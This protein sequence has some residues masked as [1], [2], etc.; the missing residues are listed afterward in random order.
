MPRFLTPS[1]IGLLALVVL[2]ADSVLPTKSTVPFLTF[3]VKYILPPDTSSTSDG[4]SALSSASSAS[5]P[6]SS[7]ILL[8]DFQEALIIHQSI[9]P[10][11]NMWDLFLKKLWEINSLDALFLFFEGLPAMIAKTRQEKEQDI[12]QGL[13]P[14]DTNKMLLSRASPMGNFVRRS[15]LE[16]TRLQF[17]DSK[18]LW[19]SLVSFRNETLSE[20]KRR[21]STAGETSFDVNLKD[22][23]LKWEDQLTT[24]VYEKLKLAD[25][26]KSKVEGPTGLVSTDDVERLLEFQVE[27]M[28]KMGNR[29]PGEIKKQLRTMLDSGVTVPSL[30]QY[31]KF[32]DAWRAGD[33]PTSFES[34]HRYFDYTMH[35]R[36]RTFYQYAL[37]NLAILQADFGCYSE[38]LAA[39]RETIA[40]ARENKD[41][42]CLNFSLSWLYHFGKVH[43]GEVNQDTKGGMMGVER[44]GLAFLKAKAKENGMWSLMATSLL[45]EARMI[46]ANHKGE[47]L[48]KAFENI[49]QSSHLS[50]VKGVTNVIG[51]QV[52]LKSSLWSRLGQLAIAPHLGNTETNLVFIPQESALSRLMNAKLSSLACV[53]QL[54]MTLKGRYDDAMAKLDEIEVED[55]KNLRIYQYWTTFSGLLKLKR[56]LHRGNFDAA[57]EFLSQL[58]TAP[59]VD[60]DVSFELTLLRYDLLIRR[61]DYSGALALLEKTFKELEE[62]PADIHQRIRLMTLKA[63]LFDKC[64][65]TQ[66]GW[67]IAVRAMSIAKRAKNLSALYAAVGAVSKCLVEFKE[68]DAAWKLMDS[69]MPQIHEC[70]DAYLI[71]QSYSCFIDATM[72]LAGEAGHGS[73]KRTEY[74]TK[75]QDLLDKAFAEFSHAEDIS[76]MLEVL[77]KKSTAYKMSGDLVLC[78]EYALK[79]VALDERWDREGEVESQWG[80][81]AMVNS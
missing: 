6:V 61:S 43:P 65:R 18:A 35:N 4:S 80:R 39:M 27:E 16:F 77:M 21:N 75:A 2:Y 57:T 31:V 11:R 13:P 50:V 15:H 8:E 47:N 17:H 51:S 26:G 19:E 14:Q 45:S 5:K 60:P 44:E 76:G 9:I 12:E 69:I 62:G 41:L 20:W 34:L 64:G 58:L 37:L 79:Y 73:I 36:D 22:S 67:S 24:I 23:G 7:V 54:Q 59:S 1:K 66:K 30:S 74:I 33:Y 48:A 81:G 10:G 55:M 40:T 32:L 46:M 42:G 25:E 56:Q 38:A 70:E 52:L 53:L 68:C 3:L 63:Q 72:G 28:Q 71:G 49:S 29:I 78:N